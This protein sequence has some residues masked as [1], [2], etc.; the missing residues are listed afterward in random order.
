MPVH[1]FGECANMD[2]FEQVA[3]D[4]K[5]SIIEDAAQAFGAAWRKRKAGAWGEAAAF[6]FYPTKNLNAFGDAGCVTTS[7]PELAGR[8]RRLRNHGSSRR[9]Y[10]QEMGGNSRMDAIQ[11][12]VL[13]IKLRHLDEWNARRREIAARYDQLFAAAALAGSPRMPGT[14]AER[15]S[16]GAT[17][18]PPIRGASAE[19]R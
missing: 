2:V 16:P 17:Y 9:Y 7:D 10:H 4:Y 5:L 15:L 18:L 12:A 19:A 3:Q 14:P 8:V 11:G 6:S 1:L 13:R